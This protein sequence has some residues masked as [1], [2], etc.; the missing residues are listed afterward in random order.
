MS[1]PASQRVGIWVITIVLI[2]GTLGSFLAM[3]LSL[4]NQQTDDTNIQTIFAK[5]QTDVENQSK[6][7]SNQYYSEF[8]QY[9]LVPAA[10]EASEV[11]E[12]KVRDIK[13]GA[14]EEINSTTA[15]KAYYIGWNPEGAIFDQSID[16][17]VLKAPIEGGN[18]IEGWNEGVVGMKI[19]GVREITIPSEKAYGEA[20]S[21]E[22]IPPNTPL[23]FIV[24]IPE[25]KEVPIP[26][27]IL[28]YYAS[29]MSS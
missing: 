21:G 29:Q 3:A 4:N 19:G 16:G 20:G 28:E 25:V 7:L 11:T 5:Y 15:Y 6:E 18:L 2:I 8:V 23:K 9:A 1:T 13:V 10:F 17:E 12:L 26:Q 14:G 27:E 24:M 22:N